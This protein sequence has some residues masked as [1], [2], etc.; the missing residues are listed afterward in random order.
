MWLT[1]EA[2][3]YCIP[4]NASAADPSPSQYWLAINPFGAATVLVLGYL[5]RYQSIPHMSAVKEP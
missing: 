5:S 1:L 2:E 3:D 4:R